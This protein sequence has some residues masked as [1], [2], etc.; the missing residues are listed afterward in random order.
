[1]NTRTTNRKQFGIKNITN[2]VEKSN[3]YFVFTLEL[4]SSANQ[5]LIRYI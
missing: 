2:F 5:S 4:I 3:Q 1:M